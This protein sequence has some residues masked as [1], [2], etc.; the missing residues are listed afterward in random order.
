VTVLFEIG[1]VLAL[2]LVNGFLAMSEMAMVSSR[3]GRLE[4]LAVQGSRGA[5]AAAELID[6][7]TRFLSTV[8]V[9]ITLV[10]ILAGAFSG[11]TLGGHLAGVLKELGLAPATAD[12]LAIVGVVLVITYLSLIVGE[13]VPKRLALSNPEAIAARVARPMMLIAGLTAPL[14]WLLRAS[15]NGVLRLLGIGERPETRVSED[16]IR[17][18]LAEGAEAGVVKRV[19]HEMIEGIMRIAD[20]PVRAIMTPRVEVRWLDVHDPPDVVRKEIAEGGHTRYPVCRGDLDEIIGIL[21]LRKLVDGSSD[22]D[23]VDLAILAE[24]PLMVHEGA[25]IIRVIELF[26]QTPV[27]MAIVLDEYGAV[28]GLVTPADVLSAIAGELPEGRPDEV[29]EAVQRGD[30]SWL[31]DGRMDIHRV[32]RLLSVRGMSRDDEYATL[33]GFVLWEL[34]RMPRV[35]ESFVWHDLRF[36]V[37]DLDGRRIDKVLVQP[38]A[39]GEAPAPPSGT[40]AGAA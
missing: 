38:A 22:G 15:T 28:E 32:E 4:Q 27:H 10:G 2:M 18:L 25:S 16:E 29:T 35:G 8:Q 21:H 30:G 6:D 20:R 9:G 5:R 7:P 17:A 11:A 3:R 19:E 34:G 14:V 1:I 33:A 40:T 24:P 36:E 39:Q 12:T 31:V 26:R 23:P 37:V 13:L